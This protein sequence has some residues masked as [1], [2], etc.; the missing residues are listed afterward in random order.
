MPA[1][2]DARALAQISTAWAA[3]R[4]TSS[5]IHGWAGV[6]SVRMNT[7]PRVDSQEGVGQIIGRRIA[8]ASEWSVTERPISRPYHEQSHG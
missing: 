3:R 4:P 2:M 6:A 8:A 1:E 7:V 5:S